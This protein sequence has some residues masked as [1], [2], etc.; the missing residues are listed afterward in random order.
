MVDGGEKKAIEVIAVK[1]LVLAIAILLATGVS[2]FAQPAAGTTVKEDRAQLDSLRRSGMK[3]FTTLTTTRR[4]PTSWR[5]R[6]SIK[7]S[8]GPAT[9]RGAPLDQDALRVAT[10]AVVSLQ[11][12]ELLSSGDDKV[13]ESSPSFAI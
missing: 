10:I 7:S 3:R 4:T 13:D 2:V 9:A 12:R 8:G 6:G 1:T 5:S 11:F